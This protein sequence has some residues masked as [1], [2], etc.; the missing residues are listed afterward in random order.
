MALE[1]IEAK[2]TIKDAEGNPVKDAEG[3][4]TYAEIGRASCRERV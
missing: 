3:K 4:P 2:Y 1:L